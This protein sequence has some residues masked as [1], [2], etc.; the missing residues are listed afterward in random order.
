LPKNRVY[1]IKMFLIFT[2]VENFVSKIG[3]FEDNSMLN[4]CR[5]KLNLDLGLPPV[6]TL[7]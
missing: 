6:F 5:G 2:F 1:A 3:W 7:P 4:N